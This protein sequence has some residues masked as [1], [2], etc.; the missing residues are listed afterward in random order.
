IY[1]KNIAEA[2]CAQDK[3]N[4]DFYQANAR[5]Y[6]AKLADLENKIIKTVATIPQEKR[7]VVVGHN[8]FK[9]FE[10]AYGIHFLSPQGISTESE[11]SAADVAG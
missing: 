4:C 10:Q 11:A 8:A 6:D 2:F 5:A 9:Y 7:T 1:V 3:S